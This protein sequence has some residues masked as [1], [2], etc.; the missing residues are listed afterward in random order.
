M[1][2]TDSQ[3]SPEDDGRGK[4]GGGGGGRKKNT[5]TYHIDDKTLSLQIFARY[6]FTWKNTDPL[7][8][9]YILGLQKKNNP[10]NSNTL[11]EK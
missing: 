6:L 9:H 3:H 4:K 11:S 1:K 5:T 8:N 7:K 2:V 10:Y